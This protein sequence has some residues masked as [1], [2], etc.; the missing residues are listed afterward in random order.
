MSSFGVLSIGV[1][2]EM[3]ERCAPG[4]QAKMREHNYCLHWN[5]KTF[6]SLPLGDHGAKRSTGRAE[7]KI[8]HV[9]KLIR[10][11]DIKACAES[12][13]PSLTQ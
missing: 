1:V 8:G 5:D 11:F 2:F 6:P 13:I 9:R 3:L 4:F 7:I 12:V 10:I